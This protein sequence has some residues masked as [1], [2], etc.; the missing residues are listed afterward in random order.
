MKN[1]HDARFSYVPPAGIE[2]ER[3]RENCSFPVKEVL[4]T[5]GS[6]SAP[7]PT[8]IIDDSI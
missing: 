5:V 7:S 4:G 6:K 1:A 8:F 3:G 2:R